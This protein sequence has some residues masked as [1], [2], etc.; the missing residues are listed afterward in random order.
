MPAGERAHATIVDVAQRAGVAISSV[1]AALNDR[2]GV[3][4]ATR[5]RIRRAA[6]ELGYV[7]SIRG[8]ALSA[9]RAFSVGL[10]VERDFTVLEADPF[11]GAFIGGVEET[12]E[13]NGY[14]LSLQIAGDAASSLERQV[15]L[16]DARRVDGVFLN[17]IRTNDRR[18][19]ALLERGLPA[20]GINPPAGFPFPAVRQDGSA[21]VHELVSAMAALGHRRIAHVTGRSAYVHTEQRLAAWTDAMSAAGLSP[22]LVLA[23]DFTYAGGERAADQL[24][25]ESSP[26]TAVFC[27]NDL[28]ALG[29]MSRAI[30]R[31]LRVPDDISVVGF[32]GIAVGD[33]VRPRLT[34]VHTDPRALGREGARLLL[35]LIDGDDPDDVDIPPA[36][37][38][39]KGSLGPVRA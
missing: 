18:I 33:Y 1:S 27:A 29:F 26:P 15:K 25:A 31:G 8:R 28:M 7:P 2:K 4:S 5:D 10:V 32:D 13:P 17:E 38:V 30:E 11:F 12:L 23:G 20:V 37:L 19:A 24:L 35:A 39:D 36:S 16:A 21:A 6:D 3:S 14:A 22:E 9:K 34:S